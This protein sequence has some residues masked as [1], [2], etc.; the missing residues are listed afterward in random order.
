MPSANGTDTSAT[1]T[2]TDSADR[3]QR[4]W[5][6]AA[7]LFF[8]AWKF[9]LT[10]IL[11][12]GR[13]IP[14][15]PDDAYIYIGHI[16]AVTR[17]PWI[18]CADNS[19]VSLLNTTGYNYLSYRVVLGWLSWILSIAPATMFHVSFYAGA[20]LL[21]P[22]L[23]F[24]FRRILASPAATPFVLAVTGLFHG[25]GYHGFFW[26]VPSFFSLLLFFAIV[27]LLFTPGRRAAYALAVLTPVYVFT[28]PM[29]VY[30]LGILPLLW[31]CRFWMNVSFDRRLLQR[32]LLVLVVAAAVYAP[33]FILVNDRTIPYQAPASTPVLTTAV[34]AAPS[35]PP[36]L[37]NFRNDYMN[38]VLPHWSAV[39]AWVVLF[40]MLWRAREHTLLALWLA[41]LF[42]VLVACTV[43]P[44]GARAVL[45]LWPVT[46]A[47]VGS[48]LWHLFRVTA[49]IVHHDRARR[50]GL[51]GIAT[52]FLAF[53]AANAAYALANATTASQ[54]ENVAIDPAFA[55][56]LVT[57]T[58]PGEHID[59]RDQTLVSYSYTTELTTRAFGPPARWV[60][61]R[62]D[63]PEPSRATA[64]DRFFGIA[65]SVFR[66]RTTAPSR[67]SPGASTTAQEIPRTRSVTT[68]GPI[69]IFDTLP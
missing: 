1:G 30:L 52:A 31:L 23:V 10:G 64:L 9:F 26:V 15:E 4:R 12:H 17:C 45:V 18:A 50:V 51:A 54:S 57:R 60:I 66:G 49:G 14:P 48:G 69:H 58:V 62:R 59:I 19:A 16:Y 65:L 22:V 8:L 41:C 53:T 68:F 24:L 3:R 2:P 46:Y 25:G 21:V 35:L 33:V 11:W 42:F 7:V 55:Q 63:T 44:Q 34:A 38:W 32:V 5:L 67:S 13:S 43:H 39:L 29:S 61:T 20:V 40:A 28:H 27:G 36:G 47:L 37:T 6:A 56:Y